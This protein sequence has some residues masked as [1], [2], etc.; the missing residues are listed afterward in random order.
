M[1]G[2]VT[3]AK[4]HELAAMCQAQLYKIL[5]TFRRFPRQLCWDVPR[6]LLGFIHRSVPG[7]RRWAWRRVAS[8]DISILSQVFKVLSPNARKS[9]EHGG[10]GCARFANLDCE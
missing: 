2:R 8:G 6:F 9:A 3:C 5:V 4:L 10:N 7:T 1:N